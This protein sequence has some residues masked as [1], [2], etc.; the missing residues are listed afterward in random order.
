M[1]EV[2]MHPALTEDPGHELWKRDFLGASGLFGITL[3]PCPRKAVAAMVDGLE[4]FGMGA[5][6]GGYES[7]V[8]PQDPNAFRSVTPWPY[9]GQCLRFHIGLEDTDDLITDLDAGFKRLEAA[10]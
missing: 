10:L 5:S 3:K 4:L 2:V 8:L 9:E 1:V 7:L 6:W